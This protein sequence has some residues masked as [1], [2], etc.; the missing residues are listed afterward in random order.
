MKLISHI[1]LNGHLSKIQ[2]IKFL[3][4]NYCCKSWNKK[5]TVNLTEEI[6]SVKDVIAKCR[7]PSTDVAQGRPN[8]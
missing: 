2:I 3:S 7:S 8:I 5:F 1:F 4:T 6:A